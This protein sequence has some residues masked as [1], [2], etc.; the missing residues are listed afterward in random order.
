MKVKLAESTMILVT[1]A[2]GHIGNVLVREL[3]GRGERVRVLIRPGK[4][5]VSLLGLGIEIVQGDILDLDSLKRAMDG[6]DI[7]YHLAAKVSILPGSDPQVERVNVE[8]T[9]NVISAARH[10]KIRRLIYASSIYA[11]RIPVEGL[12]DETCPFDPDHARGEYDRSKA[13]ASLEVQKAVGDG[14]DAVIL[15]PTA[16]TGPYDFQHSE[17]GRAIRLYMQTGLNFYIDGAYDFADVRD[18]AQGFILAAEKGRRGETYILGGDRL[19]VRE[20][21]ELIGRVAGGWHTGIC[22]PDWVADLAA[23]VLPLFSDDP[24]V[25]PYSLG[26]VRSNSHISHDKAA[27]ELGYHARPARQAIIDAIRWLQAEANPIAGPTENTIE[28]AI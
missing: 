25:T 21:A 5:P 6:T 1:G 11:M 12:V 2:T 24:L 8:G 26:A 18:V 4:E 19:T 22:L 17:A 15:C 20:V 28:A 16:V 3:L 14:L 13:A 23:E 7:V 10:A 9:R 27:R